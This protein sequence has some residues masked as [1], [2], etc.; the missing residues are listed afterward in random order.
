MVLVI[1][2][3]F[4]FFLF[5]C[6]WC[7][8][9]RWK[10]SLEGVAVEGVTLEEIPTLRTT[11]WEPYIARQYFDSSTSGVGKAGMSSPQV[12]RNAKVPLQPQEIGANDE[13][14][15]AFG[16]LENVTW[17]RPY[18]EKSVDTGEFLRGARRAVLHVQPGISAARAAE[19]RRATLICAQESHH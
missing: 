19:G 15:A 12:A 17:L 11:E 4:S 14:R 8:R 2:F 10:V 18:T 1:S 13:P 7:L 5:C 6:C 3:S 16:R 9:S